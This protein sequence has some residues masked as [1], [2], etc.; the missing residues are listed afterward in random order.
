M[1]HSRSRPSLRTLL[2]HKYL[3]IWKDRSRIL[4]HI[5]TGSS[6]ASALIA[7]IY[8]LWSLAH[9]AHRPATTAGGRL[10]NMR[11]TPGGEP[12]ASFGWFVVV[13]GGG[14]YRSR[15][16]GFS[17]GALPAGVPRRVSGK[18]NHRPPNMHTVK[19][20]MRM[21]GMALETSLT[22]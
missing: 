6:V 9:R 3:S 19:A 16:G 7:A 21:V 1:A 18:T 5:L 14:G 12:A 2:D 17:R 20:V 8:Q 10:C 11:G 13:A 4:G 15:C 22:T